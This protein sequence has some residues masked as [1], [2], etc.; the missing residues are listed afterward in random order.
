MVAR[1]R[2]RATKLEAQLKLSLAEQIRKLRGSTSQ[3]A[4]GQLIGKP[5]SVVSRLEDAAYGKVTLQTLLDI[6]AAL[7]VGLSVKFTKR[8]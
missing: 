3:T 8:P 7:D 6:A 5:Q 1:D 4:F 2:G